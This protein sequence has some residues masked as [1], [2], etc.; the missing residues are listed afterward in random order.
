MIYHTAANKRLFLKM[1]QIFK[2]K[3]YMGTLTNIDFTVR[4]ELIF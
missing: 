4:K 2:F 1:I 3:I